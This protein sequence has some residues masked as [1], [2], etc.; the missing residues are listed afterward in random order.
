MDKEIKVCMNCGGTDI[1]RVVTK[2]FVG[3]TCK[4]CGYSSFFQEFPKIKKLE[5]KK[6]QEKIKKRGPIKI[7]KSLPKKYQRIYI[8]AIILLIII[9]SI[10]TYLILR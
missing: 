10:G 1:A 6:L 8:I 4:N 7:P 3:E 9:I 2:E 5:L